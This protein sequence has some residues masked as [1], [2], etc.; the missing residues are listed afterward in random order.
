MVSGEA[1]RERAY[2]GVRTGGRSER[3]RASVLSAALEEVTRVGYAELSMAQVAARADVALTT[4]HR[5]WGSKAALVTD[6]L[7]DLL[8]DGVPVPDLGS[9]ELD[10]HALVVAVVAVLRDPAMAAGLRAA[11]LLQPADLA[12]LQ[13]RLGEITDDIADLV[14]GRAIDRGELARGID[15]RRVVELLLAGVWMRSFVSGMTV[16][17]REIAAFV[18]DAMAAARGLPVAA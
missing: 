16:D 7:D 4:V 6:A 2:Q 15:R 9:M 1:P 10:F 8:A 12:R 17:D 14:V 13:A 3:V 11:M 18:A 5:R